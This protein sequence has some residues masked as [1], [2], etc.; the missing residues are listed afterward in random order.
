MFTTQV[1]FLINICSIPQQDVLLIVGAARQGHIESQA[2]IDFHEAGQPAVE[3]C[4]L[5]SYADSVTS[6]LAIRSVLPMVLAF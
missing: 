4:K 6:K 1:C 2:V 3:L 5:M